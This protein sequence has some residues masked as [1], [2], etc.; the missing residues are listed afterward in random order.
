MESHRFDA[1]SEALL[2]CVHPDLSRVMRWTLLM[3]PTEFI[4]SAGISIQES[5]CY[6]DADGQYFNKDSRYLTG[7]AVDIAIKNNSQDDEQKGDIEDYQRIANLVMKMAKK[8]SIDIEWG[9][10]RK[11]LNDKQHFELSRKTYP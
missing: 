8:F 7:H 5:F 10:E 6:L 9:G 2:R 11:D 3:S 1:D 4:I